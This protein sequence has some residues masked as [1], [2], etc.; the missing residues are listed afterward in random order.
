MHLKGKWT[1]FLILKGVC[2]LKIS[3]R[4]FLN[5]NLQI[6]HSFGESHVKVIV[7]NNFLNVRT[8]TSVQL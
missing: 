5:E 4:L 3:N 1:N 7:V 6:E 8:C 2:F